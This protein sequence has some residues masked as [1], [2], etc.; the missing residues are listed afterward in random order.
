MRT[1]LHLGLFVL[2]LMAVS[3][4]DAQDRRRGGRHTTVVIASHTHPRVP[5]ATRADVYP[6]PIVYDGRRSRHGRSAELVAARRNLHQQRRDHEEIVHIANR[7]EQATAHRHPHAQHKLERRAI[8]WIER[9]I[10]EPSNARGNGHDIQRLRALRHELTMSRG[11][12][13]YRHR[14]HRHNV[15]KARIFDELVLLSERQMRRAE[16]RV[17]RTMQVAFAR[18]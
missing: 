14:R 9:E 11:G 7:W 12:H 18:R 13:A 16:I 2:T 1:L 10:A 6:R 17:R 4:A 3:Q 5:R 8:A 15:R